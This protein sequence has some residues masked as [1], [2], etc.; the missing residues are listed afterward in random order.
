MSSPATSPWFPALVN[1]CRP[2]WYEILWAGFTD[3]NLPNGRWRWDGQ[4]W[5]DATNRPRQMWVH[6]QWRGL[7]APAEAAA[8]EAPGELSKG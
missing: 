1:P 8:G 4:V 5:R 7:A 6:D 2:G 3:E